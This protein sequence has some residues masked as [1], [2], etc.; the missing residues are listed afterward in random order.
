MEADNR[1]LTVMDVRCTWRFE[2]GLESYFR[3]WDRTMDSVYV[4]C[5]HLQHGYRL[6]IL[7][8]DRLVYD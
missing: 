7:L 6:V 8:P 2:T 1:E 4:R 3:I 5:H